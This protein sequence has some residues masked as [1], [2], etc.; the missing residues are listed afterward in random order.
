MRGREAVREGPTDLESTAGPLAW[1]RTGVEP[2][3]KEQLDF[4]RRAGVRPDIA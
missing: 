3:A 4:C 1:E 2:Q